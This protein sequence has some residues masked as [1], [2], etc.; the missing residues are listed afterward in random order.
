L[1]ALGTT[2]TSACGL[3]ASCS[4]C[5]TGTAAR[6]NDHHD[7]HYDYD[8]HHLDHED[9]Y[10]HHHRLRIHAQYLRSSSCGPR[11]SNDRVSPSKVRVDA[12]DKYEVGFIAIKTPCATV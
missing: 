12:G 7:H 10:N 3:E 2:S 5:T 9:D 6:K 8:D 11:F 1:P 4:S